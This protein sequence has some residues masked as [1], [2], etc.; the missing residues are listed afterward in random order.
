MSHG[1]IIDGFRYIFR[2]PSDKVITSWSNDTSIIDT[3]T[4]RIRIKDTGG[5]KPALVMVP[6]GPCVIEHFEPL[7]K[8]LVS[9]F[10]VICFDMPGFGFSYPKLNYDFGLEKS[11]QVIVSV[12]DVLNIKRATLSFSCVNG[13]IAIA[14]AKS[15]PERVSRLVLA[16]TPSVHTMKNQWVNRNI[17]KPMQLPFLGQ[18][19]NAVLSRKLA[20]I[21]YDM[22]LPKNSESKERLVD[23]ALSALHSGGCFCLA[24]IAQGMRNVG[25]N[26]LNG[27]EVPTTMVWGNKDWSHKNTSFES[28][29]DHVPHCEIR[30]F[31]GCGHF[32][33]LEK[34]K[35]FAALLRSTH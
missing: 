23:L 4:G 19:I 35:A 26:D 17:P 24:S 22:A 5:N 20:S 11:V 15:Y 33:Y 12:L 29:R 31:D 8:N 13:Y 14:V 6:D 25:D 3:D 28:L 30:E 2:S 27:I 1:H 21:W 10:R 32:P 7:I 34:P 16:Q 18:V 9:D